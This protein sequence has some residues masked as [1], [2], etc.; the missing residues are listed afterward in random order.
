MLSTPRYLFATDESAVVD[1]MSIARHA[2]TPRRRVLA[3]HL[4]KYPEFTLAI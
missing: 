2:G 3:S 4:L 1:H